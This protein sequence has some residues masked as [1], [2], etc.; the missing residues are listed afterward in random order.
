M[1]G[2][3]GETGLTGARKIILSVFDGFASCTGPAYRHIAGD[4]SYDA[5]HRQARALASRLAAEDTARN[6]V[7]LYGHKHRS[8]HVAYWACLLSGRALIP[9]ES[10]TPPARLV[11]I[12]ASCGATLLI[13][14]EPDAALP[15]LPGV[16]VWAMGRIPAGPCREL[17]LVATAASDGDVA[18]V[19][20]SSGSTATPKGIRITYANLADFIM[21]LRN[22]LLADIAFEAVSGTVRHCFDVSL[23][24]LWAGWLRLKPV[25]AMDHGEFVNS[26]KY[27]D[28]YADHRV[29]LWVSTPSTVQSYLCDPQFRADRLTALNT[30]LFCGEVLGKGLVQLLRE[31]FPKA[32]IINTYGPTECTV[33]VTSVTIETIHLA[34]ARPLPIGYARP[35]CT[36]SL[37]GG[38]IAIAGPCVGAGYVGLPQKQAAAFPAPGRYRTG[39]SGQPGD[40]G[41]WFFGGRLDREVKLLGMR[42]DLSDIEAEIMRVPGVQSAFVEPVEIRGVLRALRAYVHGPRVGSDLSAIAARVADQLPPAMVPKFW[43][44]CPELFLNLN[45]K[46]DKARTIEAVAALA[47]DYVHAPDMRTGGAAPPRYEIAAPALDSLGFLSVAEAAVKWHG[48]VVTLAMPRGGRTLTLLPK[49]AHVRFWRENEHLFAK[50]HRIAGSGAAAMRGV[51]GKALQTAGPDDDWAGMRKEMSGFLG[52]SKDWFQRPLAEATAGLIAGLQ[53][54][55][56]QPLRELCLGW[57]TRAICDPL[58]CN[59]ALETGARQLLDLLD[60]SLFRRMAAMPSDRTD[61]EL[62]T[63]I[64]AALRRIARGAGAESIAGAIA[65]RQNPAGSTDDRLRRIVAG[66]LAASLHMNG[67]TLFWALLHLADDPALQR[68]IG[69]EGA[70]FGDR[71]RR[72]TETPLAFAA[73]RETLRISPVTAFLERQVAAPFTLE[74][75]AFHPGQSVLFSPWMVQ[76]DPEEWSDPGRFDPGRFLDG[77][78]VPRD[79]YLPFGAGERVCPGASVVNQQLTY[80]LSV[81]CQT[82]MLAHDTD[83]RPGDVRP[84]FRIVLEPR[85]DVRL[86]S[87]RAV[88]T[89]GA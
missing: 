49:A 76:R 14:T 48:P 34:S 15:V 40:G 22:Y 27:I 31:R 82:V 68:R 57:A 19:M 11:A 62:T 32:R 87:A 26:R 77:R 33:A 12:A 45:S 38:Q 21:W 13:S 58:F 89:E 75:F 23:F 71:P 46:T 42:M 24:E 5:L 4:L 55:R 2:M 8:Y 85:G 35:G 60:D 39:D 83:T 78:P 81:I 20:Y 29:G 16:T 84:M 67:L 18:Y 28:R 53:A 72:V 65:D 37:E 36:L 52:A 1:T 74:G 86:R 70:R 41:L 54:D 25:S 64:N 51:L 56:P 6:P 17:A 10:D 47:A 7:I 50:D 79:A 88:V 66:L 9:A 30:F 43:H 61:A 73:L 80:A 3:R 44:L 59:P 69:Q 63:A